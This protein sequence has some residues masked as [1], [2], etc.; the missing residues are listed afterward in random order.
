[1]DTNTIALGLLV[2]TMF[3]IATLYVMRRRAR[4][5]RRKPTF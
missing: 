5:G 4:Q 2:L 1:M 3:V